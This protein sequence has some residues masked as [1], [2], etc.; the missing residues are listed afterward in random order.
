ME[1]LIATYFFVGYSRFAPGTLGSLLSFPL[2]YLSADKPLISLPLSLILFLLGAFFS[3]EV[4]KQK[5]EDDPEEV[6]IDE[7][8]GMVVSFSFVPFSLKT[9]LV[10]FVT[11]RILDVVKPFPI[12]KFEGLPGGLGIMAD[13]LVAGLINSLILKIIFSYV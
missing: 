12:K 8:L 1:R 9:F 11:F 10:G 7:V 3:N 5:G 6:V 2:V 4:A 13:D